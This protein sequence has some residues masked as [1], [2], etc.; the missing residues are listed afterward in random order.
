MSQKRS[1]RACV[2]GLLFA[3]AVV[4]TTSTRTQADTATSAITVAS[5]PN[6]VAINPAGTFAYVTHE[7]SNTVS[8]I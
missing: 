4:G 7:D 6:Y 3:C 8:K 1:V 2:V 5:R